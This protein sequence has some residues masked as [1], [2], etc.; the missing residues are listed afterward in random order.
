MSV[1]EV[2]RVF[3]QIRHECTKNREER[4]DPYPL[5]YQTREWD[6]TPSF[7][8]STT[9]PAAFR[10]MACIPPTTGAADTADRAC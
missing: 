1:L 2:Q 6:Y 8:P 5:A 7:P 4:D 10:Q 3:I 9:P